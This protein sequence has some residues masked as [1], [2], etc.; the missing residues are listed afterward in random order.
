MQ[1]STTACVSTP[2]RSRSSASSRSSRSSRCRAVAL[3]A[4]PVLVALAE[5]RNCR[6]QNPNQGRH[7]P[8]P[9][10]WQWAAMTAFTRPEFARVLTETNVC[11]GGYFADKSYAFGYPQPASLFLE[12]G[13]CVT[14]AG[15]GASRHRGMDDRRHL[16][17]PMQ[18]AHA[19]PPEEA[20]HSAAGKETDKGASLDATSAV[21]AR[22]LLARCAKPARTDD[23]RTSDTCVPPAAP[24][25]GRRH[26]HR[27]NKKTL[28]KQ[29]SS[30]VK[31]YRA[32]GARRLPALVDPRIEFRCEML[33][34]QAH[35]RVAV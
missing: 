12:L 4:I 19:V 28:S 27:H 33:E 31:L 9:T 26:V 30:Y 25:A 24:S 22:R 3:V 17:V 7:D 35:R 15:A 21:S 29:Y 23:A 11:V 34:R 18:A 5:D 32:R 14:D 1:T 20:D 8:T 10:A 16:V 6:R 13:S 2:G